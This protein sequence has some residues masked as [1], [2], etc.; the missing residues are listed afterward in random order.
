MKPKPPTPAAE[1]LPP[2][3]LSDRNRLAMH[4][5]NAQQE[6][7]LLANLV[8]PHAGNRIDR[9]LV[10]H[11]RHAAAQLRQRQQAMMKLY[12]DIQPEELAGLAPAGMTVKQATAEA[13]KI[14]RQ[15]KKNLAEFERGQ[16]IP[17]PVKRP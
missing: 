17:R 2:L 12:A 4:V 3:T 5:E 11:L 13:N 6:L 7:E 10:S 15:L 16:V 14:S 9:M 1:Y 8:E